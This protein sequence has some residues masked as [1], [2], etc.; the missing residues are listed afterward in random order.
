MVG[1]IIGLSIPSYFDYLP[2]ILTHTSNVSEIPQILKN[3]LL[4]I[5]IELFS[6][7]ISGLMGAIIGKGADVIIKLYER[8]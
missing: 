7:V 5:I 1:I 4:S 6:G 2:Q 3:I 8:N